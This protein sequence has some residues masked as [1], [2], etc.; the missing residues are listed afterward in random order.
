MRPLEAIQHVVA[1]NCLRGLAW[2]ND[3]CAHGGEQHVPTQYAA[4]DCK[5]GRYYCDP[6]PDLGNVQQVKVAQRLESSEVVGLN[7]RGANALQ[8]LD[9]VDDLVT[10][11]IRQDV[12]QDR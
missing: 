8:P 6:L 2:T 4:Q 5:Q 7:G 10:K 12:L 11:R 1:M 9:L 3:R